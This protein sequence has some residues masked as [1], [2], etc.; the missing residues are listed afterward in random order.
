MLGISTPVFADSYV[1]PYQPPPEVDHRYHGLTLEAALGGGS[2]SLDAS[3]GCVT[4]AIGGWMSRDIALAFRVTAAGSYHFVGAS[5]QVRATPSLWLGGGLGS[6]GEIGMD[7][8][9]YSTT[10]NGFGGFARI[11]YQV[12]ETGSHALY[13]SAELQGGTIGGELRTVGLLA[14][15]Y[16]YL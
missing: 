14:I 7:E 9:G 5:V 4:F 15:G 2:T 10:A 13:L 1:V 6:L 12:A 3:T 11:G 16:Q 8:F